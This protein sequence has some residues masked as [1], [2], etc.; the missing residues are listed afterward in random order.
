MQR[1]SPVPHI[2]TWTSTAQIQIPLSAGKFER[3]LW[4]LDPKMRFY[5]KVE[6]ACYALLALSGIGAIFYSVS[7]FL[8]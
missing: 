3:G 7:V 8:G 1:S 2:P 5:Q 6:N 4:K